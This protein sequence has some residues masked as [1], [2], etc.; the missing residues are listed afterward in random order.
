MTSRKIGV[1]ELID[2]GIK[3][4]QNFRKHGVAF[5]SFERL[6]TGT[7]DNPAEAI[8]DCLIQIAQ[9]GFDTEDMPLRIMARKKWDML[10]TTPSA[11]EKYKHVK[12]NKVHYY[13]SI[14]WNEKVQIIRKRT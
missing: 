9:L 2:H 13:V 11:A 8:V 6:A 12:A 4:D 5:S 3:H 7:G 10:P 14:R 1:F